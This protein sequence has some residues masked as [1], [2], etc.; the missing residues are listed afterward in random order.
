MTLFVVL[1]LARHSGSSHSATSGCLCLPAKQ[2][3]TVSHFLRQKAKS[4]PSG[5]TSPIRQPASPFSCAQCLCP[6][7]VVQ[8]DR[9]QLKG[10][11]QWKKKKLGSLLMR[12]D[13]QWRRM[14]PGPIPD[15]W[16]WV[17][18]SVCRQR[19]NHLGVH[20]HTQFSFPFCSFCP[21]LYLRKSCGFISLIKM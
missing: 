6:T 18:M 14:S 19:T 8:V 9:T 15:R 7:L 17:G 10:S 21:V 11:L 13:N 20:F 2:T 1:I 3:L 12:T 4:V 16:L 5:L